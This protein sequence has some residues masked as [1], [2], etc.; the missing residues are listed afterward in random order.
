V[1]SV[2]RPT[3]QGETRGG[4]RGKVE[5]GEDGT[6]KSEVDPNERA[7][8]PNPRLG[9]T[10]F[11]PKPVSRPVKLSSALFELTENLIVYH[12]VPPAGFGNVLADSV[13][14]WIVSTCPEMG[15][16]TF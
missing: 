9:K 1:L 5:R 13:K 11:P 14:P 16:E 8:E 3:K 15:Q 4:G 7:M 2:F 10:D 6:R 12:N